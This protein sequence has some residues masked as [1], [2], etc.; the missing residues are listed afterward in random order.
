MGVVIKADWRGVGRHQVAMHSK[1]PNFL[2]IKINLSKGFKYC[3]T[4]LDGRSGSKY[5][6]CRSDK[7][8][9]NFCSISL[10]IISCICYDFSH[11]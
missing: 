5:R 10:A 2:V 9:D 1:L 8:A 6:M 11:K 4:P 7:V 3:V